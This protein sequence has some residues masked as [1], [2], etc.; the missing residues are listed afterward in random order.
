MFFIVKL[1]EAL[2]ITLTAVE[3]L[4]FKDAVPKTRQKPVPFTIT[5]LPPVTEKAFWE[6]KANAVCK[7]SG[8]FEPSAAGV[9]SITGT[10][11]FCAI[12]SVPNPSCDGNKLRI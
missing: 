3:A 12:K 11:T 8:T 6:P 5:L 4:D 7:F 9:R 2:K 1:S 10:M